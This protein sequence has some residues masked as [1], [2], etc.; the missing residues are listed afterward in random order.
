MKKKLFW[1]RK[2]IVASLVIQEASDLSEDLAI[3]NDEF[4]Y[5]IGIHRF[6]L[7]KPKSVYTRR[8]REVSVAC[9][10]SIRLKIKFQNERALLE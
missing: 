3:E 1:D 9:R 6:V 5:I 8:T 2:T 4:F 10:R 7:I